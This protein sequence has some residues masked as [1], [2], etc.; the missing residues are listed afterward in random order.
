MLNY[1]RKKMFIMEKL[2]T[3]KLGG[4][5]RLWIF[6]SFLYLIIVIFLTANGFLKNFY[7]ID[8]Y[9]A[10]K[11][12][13]QD[14]AQQIASIRTGILAWIIPVTVLYFFGWSVGW[15]YRGFNKKN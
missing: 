1:N 13:Y 14:S 2:H 15:V 4:W 6:V 12:M 7:E 9:L 8:T 11:F 5:H 10:R 3:V